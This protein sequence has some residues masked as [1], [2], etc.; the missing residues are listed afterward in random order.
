MPFY[1]FRR[2]NGASSVNRMN[3]VMFPGNSSLY[4]DR[5]EPHICQW[6]TSTNIKYASYTTP[7]CGKL[8]EATVRADIACLSFWVWL[9]LLICHF[10]IWIVWEMMAKRY[11]KLISCYC[12]RNVNGP[13]TPKPLTR[14]KLSQASSLSSNGLPDCTI[15]KEPE[16]TTEGAEEHLR[17]WRKK[18]LY[19]CGIEWVWSVLVTTHPN[20]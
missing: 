4:S 11:S 19:I 10:V 15:S 3:G 2:K 13:D 12:S 8:N 20:L 1:F 16:P 17:R 18:V 14:P 6:L 7:P 5:W 9:F